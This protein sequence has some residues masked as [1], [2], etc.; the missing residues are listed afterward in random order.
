M[1]RLAILSVVGTAVLALSI[2][3]AWASQQGNLAVANWKLM[4]KCARQAQ[5]AFPDYT[6]EAN[7]KRDAALKACLSSN[8]LPPRP[9]LL[10][11]QSR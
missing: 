5:T 1:N 7:A 10:A 9:E 3:A 11:P 8:N 2:G 6:A 4:D